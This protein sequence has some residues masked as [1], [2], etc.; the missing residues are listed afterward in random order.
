MSATAAA[1]SLQ[2]NATQPCG[3]RT[4]TTR[5]A[6]PAGRHVT[7]KVLYVLTAFAPYSTVRVIL[8]PCT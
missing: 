2:K 4:S 6:P 5:I 8:V 7:G 1:G 3:S